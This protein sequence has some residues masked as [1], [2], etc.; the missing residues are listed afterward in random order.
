[1]LFPTTTIVHHQYVERDL[2]VLQFLWRR[3]STDIE[4]SRIPKR[5]AQWLM[6]EKR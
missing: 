2:G 4:V 1:M 5:R 3:V 6:A